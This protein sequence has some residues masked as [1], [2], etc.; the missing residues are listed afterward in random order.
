MD[1]FE[2]LSLCAEIAIAVTGFSGVVLVLGGHDRGHASEVDLVRFRLLI[3]AT[4]L[5]LAVV[6]LAFIL[7]AA[8]VEQSVAWRTCSLFWVV[9]A[10]TT[11]YLNTRGAARLN[12]GDRNLRVP[13]FQNVW[14]GGAV[15][16]SGALTVIAVQLA[17]L[18]VLHAFWPVLLAVWWGIGLSLFAFVGLLFPAEPE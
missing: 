15:A 5:P 8:E 10:S 6:A 11:A 14:R 3:S 12:T 9:C 2:A 7:A 16:L 17:N 1:P 18:I 4:L 13:R